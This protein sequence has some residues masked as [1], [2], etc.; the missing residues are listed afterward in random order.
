MLGYYLIKIVSRFLCVAPAWVS[1]SLGSLLGN[2]ALIFAPAW[3]KKMAAANIRECLGVSG[4]DA[5]CIA[6]ASLYRFG[7]MAVEFLRFPLLKPTNLDEFVEF[8]GL[9]NL[10]EAAAKDRGVI[11]ATAHFG[12]WELLG[13]AISLLG[14]D[15]L[16]IA[17]KQNNG[18]MD[19]FVNEYRQSVGQKIA[20]NRGRH[21]LMAISRALREK[22]FL[23]ILYDQD[24]NDD[25]VCLK[26]F[27]KDSVIPLGSAAFSRLY[28]TPVVPAF[29]H[30]RE[31]GKS[32]VKVY[33]ALYA[34][35]SED[36]NADC[37]AVTEKLAAILEEEISSDP[38][39][40]FWVHDR[41]KDGRR[42]FKNNQEG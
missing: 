10:R 25:G 22:K 9:E 17:R 38:S 11:I 15:M 26:L 36:K 41:W 31:D 33:P 14:Y 13:A 12:N 5:A 7:R 29:I 19:R 20:Y 4:T 40:W 32:V 37:V 23:G 39:M 2:L 24:T 8:E 34:G 42:R 16:S 27:G 6:D 28:G 21:G 35:C 1:K 18:S 3:R 30:N